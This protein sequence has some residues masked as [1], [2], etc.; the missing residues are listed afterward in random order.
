M[1]W[2]GVAPSA[3]DDGGLLLAALLCPAAPESPARLGAGS[4]DSPSERADLPSPASVSGVHGSEPKVMLGSDLFLWCPG[5]LWYLP[6]TPSSVLDAELTP[7]P[8]CFWPDLVP[9]SLI[10]FLPMGLFPSAALDCGVAAKDREPTL[11]VHCSSCETSFT[12]LASCSASAIIDARETS[13]DFAF[14]ALASSRAKLDLEALTAAAVLGCEREEE[15]A[16][17]GEWAV[18]APF[19]SLGVGPSRSSKLRLTSEAPEGAGEGPFSPL[20]WDRRILSRPPSPTGDGLFS[21]CCPAPCAPSLRIIDSLRSIWFVLVPRWSCNGVMDRALS[22]ARCHLSRLFSAVFLP[23]ELSSAPLA[24]PP[25]SLRLFSLSLAWSS[26]LLSY[27]LSLFFSSIASFFVL[28]FFLDDLGP[29]P[30]ETSNRCAFS[31][32][33][34]FRTS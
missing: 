23:A 29:L 15:A 31:S 32:V 21:L 20:L 3:E 30:P 18:P 5:L 7:L 16:S 1:G 24:A 8:P 22:R 2:I 6:P 11:G 33:F 34:F 4:T 9:N 25:A 14:A 13:T 26:A 27:S 19:S 10:R 28:P 17:L 12:S